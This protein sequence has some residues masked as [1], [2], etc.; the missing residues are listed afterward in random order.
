[1]NIEKTKVMGEDPSVTNG[2]QLTENVPNYIYLAHT[3]PLDKENQTI[4]INRRK[5]LAWTAFS[6]LK[7]SLKNKTIPM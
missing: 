5:R 3:R 2:N 1:M 4:E 7:N 6:K